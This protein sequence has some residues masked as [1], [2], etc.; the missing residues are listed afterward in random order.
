MKRSKRAIVIILCFAMCLTLLAACGGSGVGD[1]PSAT[2]P[3]PAAAPGAA[4]LP[5][6]STGGEMTQQA[7]RDPTAIYADH[8]DV[9]QDNNNTGVLNP[10]IPAANTTPTNWVFT[11]IHDRL[12]ER[13]HSTG[14]FL[15]ALAHKWETTDF[16]TFVF[17]LRDDVYF[18]NGEKFTADDVVFTWEQAKAAPPGT[19]A[20]PQWA[21]VE[22]ATAINPTTVE[23]RLNRV[24][25]DF[26]FNMTMPSACIVNKK[27]VE[28][29]PENGYRIGTGPYIVDEFVP[30]DYTR[31][32]RND[33][34]WN[35]RKN[36][37]TPTITLR[38]VPE[39]PARTI[40]MQR[41]E[42]Q[43]S[44]GISAED[45]YLFEADPDNFEVVPQTFNTMQGFSF[46]LLD[47]ICAD[48][49]FRLAVCHALDNDEIALFAASEWASGI[50]DG[51]LWGFETEFR[52]NDIPPLEYNPQIA[53][54]YLAQSIYNGEEIEIAAAIIT[55]I[56]AAQAMQQ[57]LAA[58]GINS[59]VVEYD[60]PGLTAYIADPEGGAQ[61]VFLSVS[62]NYAS[63]SFR[64]LFYPNAAQNRMSYSNPLVTQM[65]DEAAGMFDKAQR[66]AHYRK[67]Q[68]IVA[69]DRPFYQVYW[70]IN[71]TVAARGLGGLG[72]PADNLQ[73]DLRELY[74]IIG[75]TS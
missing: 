33:N 41:G 66:E 18:H 64:N 12:L 13:N 51:G 74:Y 2:G 14:E 44:F 61:I 20:G 10:Y 21:P 69:A 68:E 26:Y 25:I 34:F 40:R 73:N 65:L 46:N 72:I 11:M 7:P 30:N 56:R 60:S 47:P 42:S 15:P 59:R 48:L 4:I 62:M 16:Q 27:A 22:Q 52:N 43:L 19:Q 9:I 57:Q 24:F 58:I 8:I 23:L 28:A 5:P 31:F 37:I 38:F 36:I 35:E 39:M 50:H 54:D 1:S 70:R 53:K 71:A 63:S 45:I 32:V 17:H 75:Y 6:S 55:N 29:D 67:M 49:N 3:G